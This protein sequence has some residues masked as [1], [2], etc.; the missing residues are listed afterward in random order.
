VNQFQKNLEWLLGFHELFG[1]LFV[2]FLVSSLYLF[3]RYLSKRNKIIPKEI[4][5]L[6]IITIGGSIII[7]AIFGV[8]SIF[9]LFFFISL[10]ITLIIV[11][12]IIKGKI[13]KK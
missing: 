3:A 9:E 1:V 8:T 11:E 6:F 12:R 4:I 13:I 10:S 2:I 7:L 5:S